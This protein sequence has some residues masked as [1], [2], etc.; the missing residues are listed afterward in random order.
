M[1]SNRVR[2]RQH[3]ACM[4]KNSDAYSIL[5]EKGYIQVQMGG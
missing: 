3:V 4:G 2:E 1:K 5:M